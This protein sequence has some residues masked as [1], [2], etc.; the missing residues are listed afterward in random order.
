M[1]EKKVVK[2]LI[3]GKVMTM[4]GYESEEYMQKVAAYINSKIEEY[5]KTD[6]FR[7]ASSDIRHRMLEL[8]F[9]DSYFKEKEHVEDLELRLKEK[10]NELDEMKHNYV[11][12]QVMVEDQKKDLSTLEAKLREAETTITRLQTT[13]KERDKTLTDLQSAARE[14]GHQTVVAAQNPA[15]V[16]A[17]AQVQAPAGAPAAAPAPAPAPAP[18]ATAPKAAEPQFTQQ[19]IEDLY[20]EE[21]K[22]AEREPIR[23]EFVTASTPKED[24]GAGEGKAPEITPTDTRPSGDAFRSNRNGKRRR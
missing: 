8:N 3:A 7:H 2:V 14:Q 10:V 19:S 22:P 20:G 5:E 9:A 12:S 23:V 13:L 21:V 6:A 24:A 17:S 15:P 1:A 11:N 4:S 16:Q 18:S